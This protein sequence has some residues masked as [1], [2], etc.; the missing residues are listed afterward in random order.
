MEP[1]SVYLGWQHVADT[2][3]A[4]AAITL[5]LCRALGV[6]AYWEPAAGRLFVH[7][8]VQGRGIVL[9]GDPPL[10]GA[11]GSAAAL[12]RSAGARVWTVSAAELLQAQPARR[13]EARPD[14]LV[15]LRAVPDRLVRS[16]AYGPLS[17]R[18][19]DLADCVARGI[20]GPAGLSL[21]PTRI[22]WVEELPLRRAGAPAVLA[23]VGPADAARVAEGL[24][25]GVSR[26][27]APPGLAG[28]LDQL[29][30]TR[31]LAAAL[32]RPVPPAYRQAAEPPAGAGNTPAGG[33][34]AAGPGAPA[35]AEVPLTRVPPAALPPGSPPGR[36]YAFLTLPGGTTAFVP[37]DL[38]PPPSASAPAT[39]GRQ[40]LPDVPAHRPEA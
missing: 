27:F 8:P 34:P 33:P 15:Y 1:T 14:A 23:D 2:T 26:H 35:A 29:A 7:S 4:G 20:A 9:G 25:A 30:S 6:E 38:T 24:F 5:L 40:P 16:T 28:L 39:S 18:T 19:R 11:V 10:A 22:A 31:R 21:Q 13:Q 32:Q 3:P 37:L 12:L 36:V 17:P